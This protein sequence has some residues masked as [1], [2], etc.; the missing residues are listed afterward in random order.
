MASALPQEIL[1]LIADYVAIG[2]NGLFP[3]TLVDKSWQS[4]F[5]RRIY[6]SVVVLSPSATTAVENRR[7][8]RDLENIEY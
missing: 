4:A 3:Y 6:A 5:E 1:S 7:Y 8:G 2:D